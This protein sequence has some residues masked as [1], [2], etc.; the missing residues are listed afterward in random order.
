MPVYVYSCD[1]CGQMFEQRQSISAPPLVRCPE[2][3]GRVYR[4]IQPVGIVFKG[5]GFYVTDHRTPSSTALPGERKSGSGE[6]KDSSE[7][8]SP[9]AAQSGRTDLAD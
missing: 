4:V 9:K 3:G 5:K 6:E 1:T 2:C 7:P 8:A